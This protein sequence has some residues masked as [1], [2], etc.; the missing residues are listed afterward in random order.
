MVELFWQRSLAM[1]DEAVLLAFLD[2]GV[3]EGD[4]LE[5]KQASYNQGDKFEFTDEFLETIV[6]FAN[7]GGGMIICGVGEDAQKRPASTEGIRLVPRAGGRPRDP[8][9][10]LQDTSASLVTPRVPL[11]VRSIPITAGSHAGNS[12][13]V[14]QVRRGALPPYSLRD[15]EI[16]IRN[17]DADRRAR[18]REIE[19]LF[20]RRA[21]TTS[22]PQQPWRQMQRDVFHYDASVNLGPKHLMVGFAPLFS[23]AASG[24]PDQMVLAFRRMSQEFFGVDGPYTLLPNAA[25]YTP[26]W[27]YPGLVD[28]ER[29]RDTVEDCPSP[30]VCCG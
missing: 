9:S 7:T 12:L 3:P 26:V 4:H 14:V 6:A 13:L 19:A 1:I 22:E 25:A 18:V 21:Q 28:S 15:E 24:M 29:L 10:V 17:G 16:Y 2:E 23:P 27:S 20:S 5:Y 11:D 30:F 8:A